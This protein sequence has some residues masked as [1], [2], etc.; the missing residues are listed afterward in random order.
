[1]GTLVGAA[2]VVVG[3]SVCPVLVGAPVV[4]SAVGEADGAVDGLLVVVEI[5]LAAVRSRKRTPIR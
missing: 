4:G 1:M 3:A 2:D 5:L